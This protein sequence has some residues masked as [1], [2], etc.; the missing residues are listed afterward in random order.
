LNGSI[1][2]ADG[3][4]CKIFVGFGPSDTSVEDGYKGTLNVSHDGSN[5]P[6]E[7]TYFEGTGQDLGGD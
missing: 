3:Q 1:L 6:I 5:G 7:A 4:S 2:L